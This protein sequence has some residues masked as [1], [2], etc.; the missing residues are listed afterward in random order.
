MSVKIQPLMLRVDKIQFVERSSRP[1]TPPAGHNEMFT[2]DNG[3]TVDFEIKTNG[4]DNT[5]HTLS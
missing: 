3:K 2:Y 1:A 5:L 4:A